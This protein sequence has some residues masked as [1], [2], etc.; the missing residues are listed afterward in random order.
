MPVVGIISA[1]MAVNP[2]GGTRDCAI[3]KMKKFL[4]KTKDAVNHLGERSFRTYE[5]WRAACKQIDP[6]VTF[7]G[8]KDIC[9]AK[10]GIGEWDGNEG[11]IYNKNKD[12]YTPTNIKSIAAAKAKSV[13]MG[14]AATGDAN[15]KEE[16]HPRKGGKFVK[17]G[18]GNS[19]SIQ[20]KSNTEN[21]TTTPLLIRGR[22]LE[23]GESPTEAEKS[24]PQKE[25]YDVKYNKYL[26]AI[27]Y[28]R[29]GAEEQMIKEKEDAERRIVPLK[30]QNP[31]KD[32]IEYKG[33][34]YTARE[35]YHKLVG[36]G[37]IK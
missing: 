29:K 28:V 8:D 3:Q 27:T 2:F 22:K 12:A 5:A 37:R 21:K 7:E 32:D 1:M 11:V 10:P 19:S 31:I 26:N 25:G 35:L 34:S 30:G 18:Q 20:N 23:E 14:K 15:F 16:Q 6:S 13:A 17:K 24:A 9:Q 4:L 33:Q 36:E